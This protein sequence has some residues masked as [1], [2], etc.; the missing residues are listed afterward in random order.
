MEHDFEAYSY[1]YKNL[2]SDVL[3]YQKKVFDKF[4][5]PL[6][7]IQGNFNHGDFLKNILTTSS[8]KY[9]IFFDADAIPLKNNLYEIILNELRLEKCI[10]GIEQTGMPR[11]HIYAGPACLGLP[12]SLYSEFNFP[13]LN[14]TFRSDVAEELTWNCEE[15][16]IKVKFLKVSHVEVPKWRL[17]YDREFGIGTTFSYNSEDVLY[18]QFE[19]RLN[20]DSFIKKCKSILD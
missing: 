13:C 2:S 17:G 11:Y 20:T 9:V 8:K 3:V 6:T 5:L 16:A 10:F 12:V 4:N 18:H 14:Q 19:I 1:A 7:Q 15:N